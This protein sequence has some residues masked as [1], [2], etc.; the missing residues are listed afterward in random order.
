LGGLVHF[1]RTA[2]QRSE[3]EWHDPA[4]NAL[5]STRKTS[6]ASRVAWIETNTM[7]DIEDDGGGGSAA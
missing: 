6:D 3:V 7:R 1:P 2:P 5:R 4:E